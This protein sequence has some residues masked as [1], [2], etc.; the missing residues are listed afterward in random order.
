MTVSDRNVSSA[1]LL[2]ILGETPKPLVYIC[3]HD[4]QLPN[5]HRGFA[6]AVP[7]S[8]CGPAPHLSFAFSDKIFSDRN[9]T[10]GSSLCAKPHGK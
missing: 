10:S 3:I 8:A 5:R 4:L 2:S 9:M 7:A 1:A 6:I